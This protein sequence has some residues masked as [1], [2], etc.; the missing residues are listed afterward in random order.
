MRSYLTACLLC[1]SL[2]LLA[3]V[4]FT[5]TT[6]PVPLEPGQSTTFTL[7]FSNPNAV[8]VPQQQLRAK[9][10]VLFAP[11]DTDFD[12]SPIAGTCSDWEDAIETPPGFSSTRVVR[13]SV[14]EVAA[15]GR[16]ECAYRIARRTAG[17]RNMDLAFIN[18]AQPNLLVVRVPIGV[19]SDIGATAQHLYSTSN[20]NMFVH[21]FRI[22]IR[23]YG[24]FDTTTYGFGEC[25][26]VPRV[27]MNFPG[28]CNPVAPGLACFAVGAP[29]EFKGALLQA[30]GQ[31][32]CELETYG[33]GPNPSLPGFTLSDILTRES[34][35][36]SMLDINPTND[37]LRRITASPLVAVPGL[38]SFAALACAIVLFSIATAN[39]KR[40]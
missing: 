24:A 12:V 14:P 21:R 25:F 22:N 38:S 5:P 32:S 30:G 33:A 40:D 16:I 4:Q 20:G 6:V 18:F 37:S 36:A 35:G 34:D 26:G 2:P 7:V 9:F 10:F 28:G 17:Q 27:R 23:N 11:F 29:Q 3:Q 8:A 19:L 31:T 15:G 39:L 1:V 13:F